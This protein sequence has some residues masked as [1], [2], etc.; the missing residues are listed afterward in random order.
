MDQQPDEK[1]DFDEEDERDCTND[2][3]KLNM[4][5]KRFMGELCS[6]I[7]WGKK[8]LIESVPQEI[9]TILEPLLARQII[10]KSRTLYMVLNGSQI[11]YHPQFQLYLQCKLQN[12]HFRPELAAQCT[13]INFIVT[14]K[15]LEDQLLAMVVNH[16][17]QELEIKK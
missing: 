4:N 10:K 14:E 5:N 15:G 8:V 12:P 17:K 16:E 11:E 1:H 9:D 2:Y 3:L 7:S 13:I 6:A